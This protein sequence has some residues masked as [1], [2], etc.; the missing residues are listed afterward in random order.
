MKGLLFSSAIFF[1]LAILFRLFH[2]PSDS[3]LPIVSCFLLLIFA[4]VN[5]FSKKKIGKLNVFGGWVLFAWTLYILFKYQ[6][7]NM[8]PFFDGF[9]VFFL[10]V[11]V[12]TILYF[13]AKSKEWSKL[14][15][16]VSILGLVY[17]FVPAYVNCYFFELNEVINK[18]NNE[19]NFASWDKYSWFLFL[20]G[21]NEEALDA[22]HRAVK[23]CQKAVEVNRLSESE[24]K[25]IPNRLSQHEKAITGETDIWSDGFIRIN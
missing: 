16:V 19:T 20:N 7:W 18:E 9:S 1:S 5:T 4:V 21:K 3:L 23:A 12:L 6:Y 17:S 2:L 10:L 22:N 11:F 15:L 25:E 24:I 14:V 13:I 8:G